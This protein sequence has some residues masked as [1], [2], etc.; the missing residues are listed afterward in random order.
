MKEA[1]SLFSQLFR[2]VLVVFLLLLS[3]NL[4]LKALSLSYVP[5]IEKLLD[6]GYE[7]FANGRRK[8]GEEAVACALEFSSA[9]GKT[10]SDAVLIAA[11]FSPLKVKGILD[12]QSGRKLAYARIPSN[13]F[14]AEGSPLIPIPE[15]FYD[16][17]F[18]PAKVLVETR[19]YSKRNNWRKVAEIL[20]NLLDKQQRNVRLLEHIGQV[21]EEAEWD[22]VAIDRYEEA[23]KY[24][25]LEEDQFIL[26]YT[27]I[28]MVL[29]KGLYFKA[30]QMVSS[31]L[32][33]ANVSYNQYL[34]EQTQNLET[35]AQINQFAES[36][37]R[38]AAAYNLFAVIKALKQQYPEALEMI[39]YAINLVPGNM[40]VVLNENAIHLMAHD[41]EKSLV[42]LQGIFKS[43]QSLKESSEKLG[44]NSDALGGGEKS[45]VFVQSS[46]HISEA[47]SQVA[48]SLGRAYLSS[49]GPKKALEWFEE[50][51]VAAPEDPAPRYYCGVA[52][53]RT[54]DLKGAQI[55]FRQ[56]LDRA[57]AHPFLREAAQVKVEGLF[58]EEALEILRDKT[59]EEKVAEA[60]MDYL[61]E[62]KLY[63]MKT[64]IDK[65]VVFLS[66]GK[67][68]EAWNWFSK[69]SR[70]Y[71]NAVEPHF[72]KGL[73]ALHK[74]NEKKAATA[75]L[76]ALDIDSS[77][78]MTMSFLAYL[79]L[80]RGVLLESALEDSRKAFIASPD[81]P[82]IL[83]NFAWTLFRL[84]ERQ[85]AYGLIRDAI[86]TDPQNSLFHYRLGVMYFFDRLYQF[87][88]G[89]FDE[90]LQIH[91]QWPKPLMMK[92]LALA[93]LGRVN[94]ALPV[95]SASLESLSL[96]G[97]DRKIVRTTIESLKRALLRPG[98][99]SL[100][101][102][103]LVE[104]SKVDN[105]LS[106]VTVKDAAD[107]R[108]AWV[109]LQNGIQ[110]LV[111]GQLDR[112][113]ALLE[114]GIEEH[115]RY[116]DLSID[117]GFLSLL[118]E[119][120]KKAKV[121]FDNVLDYQA[122]DFRAL[123]GY[124][125]LSF[126][127]GNLDRFVTNVSRLSLIPPMAEYSSLLSATA[128]RWK[129]VT[130]VDSGDKAAWYEL[131]K[132]LLFSGDTDK[133]INALQSG[134]GPYKDGYLGELFLRKYVVTK[135]DVHFAAAEKY[136]SASGYPWLS[137]LSKVKVILDSPVPG[138]VKEKEKV[139]V[140][141]SSE[142]GWSELIIKALDKPQVK[143]LS[144][145]LGMKKYGKRW[146]KLDSTIELSQT[147]L[148]AERDKEAK[149]AR[150]LR[151]ADINKEGNT[152]SLKFKVEGGEVKLISDPSS[153][154]DLKGPS[155]DGTAGPAVDEAGS[156]LGT[157]PVLNVEMPDKSVF[158]SFDEQAF[159]SQDSDLDGVGIMIPMNF[160]G[161]SEQVLA[162]VRDGMS[163]QVEKLA[164]PAMQMAVEPF[165]AN[166]P[167]T[168]LKPLPSMDLP[169]EVSRQ[170]SELTK[171]V[172]KGQIL[173][174]ID[175]LNSDFQE[176]AYFRPKVFLSAIQVLSG[177][178][179]G[180]LR[181]VEDAPDL[182]S[183][184]V[185]L[186]RASFLAHMISDKGSKP[187]R[188]ALSDRAVVVRRI[189]A[190]LKEIADFWDDFL[191]E[192]QHD[193]DGNRQRAMI[194]F[195]AG[196]WGR[197]YECRRKVL[198]DETRNFISSLIEMSGGA[199]I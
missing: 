133:A 128:N 136:L 174:V 21:Y 191:N 111:S 139:L 196:D 35:A 75:F 145:D 78:P 29:K 43:L 85:E 33:K 18:L 154:N 52:K 190:E 172:I 163:L 77:H 150:I 103:G 72:Y 63:E 97:T 140:K 96:L 123:S 80:E 17:S 109:I 155:N 32:R 105:F 181:T 81:E 74:G 178:S 197:L 132:I 151:E 99:I 84:G 108:D 89:K 158:N 14:E 199:A 40:A 162:I 152:E 26:D 62:Q 64:E 173:P 87:A 53:E 98:E 195:M 129:Q 22:S 9:T 126:S 5:D 82:A 79:R 141:L 28:R 112:A 39:S 36:R 20:D 179:K 184:S 171:K 59:R 3:W 58:E 16:D 134:E 102:N 142:D 90:V 119:D 138:P 121:H 86:R 180:A 42:Q 101:E 175:S 161:S 65:G 56:A 147:A 44:G 41:R 25:G 122:S 66:E 124:A 159:P 116:A 70:R 49:N 47:M 6:K 183:D 57:E 1:S 48:L 12:G 186:E 55:S 4:P 107:N 164:S 95:L 2:R 10:W 92:G 15:N 110:S 88:I 67:F 168:V 11:E 30:E 182:T 83:V 198:D 144:S 114:Q 149:V 115:P 146:K 137:S 165:A 34:K 23:R 8:A 187:D 60:A 91:S 177:D 106:A 24:A 166:V 169:E 38:L 46:D 192:Q 188:K 117:A 176:T 120:S 185:I 69:I 131:G 68:L 45:E 19:F 71:P 93:S 118:S 189:T 27:L 148:K 160:S 170:L 153:S 13:R 37:G 167:L 135:D 94:E 193:K 143:Y 156:R 127:E 130:S 113:R 100:E 125:H 76:D 50:A 194:A 157:A 61:D 31:L 51:L 7:D 73:S 104:D 54:G